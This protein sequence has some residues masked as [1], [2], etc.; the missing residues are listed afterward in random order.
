MKLPKLKQWEP[1][2]VEWID[3]SGGRA[4]WEPVKLAKAD[5]D[6]EGLV[7]VGMVHSQRNDRLT[8]VLSHDGAPGKRRHVHSFI[9]IP[10][11]A[12]TSIYRLTPP[13]WQK[14]KRK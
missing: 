4:S 6:I 7:T 12:I 13:R 8:I 5:I 10:A 11:V 14:A 1:V 3:S 2:L 9:T